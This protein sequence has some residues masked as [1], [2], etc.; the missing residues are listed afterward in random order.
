MV[1]SRRIALAI[2]VILQAHRVSEGE[3]F[4]VLRTVS[5]SRGLKLSQVADDVVRFGP[6]A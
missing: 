5:R 1:Q 4:D 2:G 3:A 6:P